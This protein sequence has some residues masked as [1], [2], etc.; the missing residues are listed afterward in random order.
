MRL[1]RCCNEKSRRPG[2][3]FCKSIIP[4][5]GGAQ[6]T[7]KPCPERMDWPFRCEPL[8]SLA[9]RADGARLHLKGSS[10]AGVGAV[11]QSQVCD[12]PSAIAS[13]APVLRASEARTPST[14]TDSTAFA[15][16]MR[17][18]SRVPGSSPKLTS[19][20]AHASSKACRRP[21]HHFQASGLLIAKPIARHVS[22]G[23]SGSR[24]PSRAS[25]DPPI[26]LRRYC[27]SSDDR[28]VPAADRKSAVGPPQSG[29]AID[30]GE[31]TL[32][33]SQREDAMPFVRT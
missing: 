9:A 10:G 29:Q 31:G 18:F 33:R 28:S 22:S 2:R 19:M 30:R 8:G 12:R 25:G 27:E 15:N 23:C 1:M 32:Q 17:A 4:I 6:R 14:A 13:N 20:A 21:G 16:L 26:S 5:H 11:R 24:G 3:A 7:R